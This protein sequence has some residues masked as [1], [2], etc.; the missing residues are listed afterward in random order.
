MAK[1]KS[2]TVDLILESSSA[3][4]ICGAAFA[5]ITLYLMGERSVLALVVATSLPAAASLL[6]LLVA[7]FLPGVY[8]VGKLAFPLNITLPVIHC[9]MIYMLAELTRGSFG[10]L[11]PPQQ[12][13]A[14]LRWD[15]LGFLGMCLIFQILL[16]SA[17]V[18]LRSSTPSSTPPVEP[19]TDVQR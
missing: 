10:V 14:A 8:A 17:L 15:S 5:V 11:R 3:L 9:S 7:L 16:L 19:T 12:L 1:L 6:L 4:F 2:Q 13:E 18:A